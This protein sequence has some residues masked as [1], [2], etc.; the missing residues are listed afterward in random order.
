MGSIHRDP[1]G[2][3]SK[4]EM[5]TPPAGPRATRCRF[6][7]GPLHQ[8]AA[9]QRNTHFFLPVTTY[10]DLHLRWCGQQGTCTHST[11]CD[12]KSGREQKQHIAIDVSLS[13]T[14]IMQKLRAKSRPRLQ[15]LLT[16]R[17]R[18]NKHQQ[19]NYDSS[20]RTASTE[21]C[22]IKLSQCSSRYYTT[23]WMMHFAF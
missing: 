1:G 12:S 13:V 15:L 17:R 19:V 9:E 11:P 22:V 5:D 3:N 14:E 23:L 16:D 7:L 10:K 6:T 8:Q 18:I 20:R 2:H 4:G 21:V